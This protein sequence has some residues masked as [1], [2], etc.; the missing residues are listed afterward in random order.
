MPDQF[1][2][3]ES[4][5]ESGLKIDCKNSNDL[6]TCGPNLVKIILLHA[7]LALQNIRKE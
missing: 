6:N 1:A 5:K 7:K 2:D 3:K 4:R